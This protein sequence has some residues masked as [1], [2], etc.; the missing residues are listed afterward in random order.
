[1]KYHVTSEHIQTRNEITQTRRDFQNAKSI[2]PVDFNN[3]W[4][5]EDSLIQEAQ[6]TILNGL[7]F[8]TRQDRYEAVSEAHEEKFE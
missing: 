7:N 1:M 8:A 6:R 3:T 4:R 5:L 2:N